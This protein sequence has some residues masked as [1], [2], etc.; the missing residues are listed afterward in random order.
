MFSD[1]I[2]N[3]KLFEYLS[4]KTPILVF[5]FNKPLLPEGEINYKYLEEKKIT[6]E[7]QIIETIID[8]AK[9]PINYLKQNEKKEIVR[10]RR[11]KN[12]FFSFSFFLIGMGSALFYLIK[13][14]K[15]PIY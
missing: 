12:V 11:R 10:L 3:S 9:L 15:Y 2:I 8:F 7:K 4:L 1:C 6:N 5:F 13:V 14:K